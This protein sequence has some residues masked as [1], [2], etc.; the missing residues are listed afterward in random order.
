MGSKTT[1]GR[2]RQGETVWV[3]PSSSGEWVCD[4]EAV[5]LEDLDTGYLV[6]QE[7][8]RVPSHGQGHFV[9]DVEVTMLFGPSPTILPRGEVRR[10][11]R[12]W[13]FNGH[14]RQVLGTARCDRGRQ[15]RVLVHN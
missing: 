13:E 11:R 4:D 14:A 10:D 15:K 5:I 8:E 2:Y 1:K 9:C 12:L 7:S 6:L 3:A